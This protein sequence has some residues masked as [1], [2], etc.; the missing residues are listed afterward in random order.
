MGTINPYIVIIRPI[1]PLPIIAIFFANNTYII[2]KLTSQGLTLP[3]VMSNLE[4][5]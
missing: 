1:D 3:L 4:I 2:R 5:K